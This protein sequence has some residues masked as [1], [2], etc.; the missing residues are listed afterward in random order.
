MI[1][2]IPALFSGL[3]DTF[4]DSTTVEQVGDAKNDNGR[5]KLM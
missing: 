5:I 2:D 3:V 1:S 4:V